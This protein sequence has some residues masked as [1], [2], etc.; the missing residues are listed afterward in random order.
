MSPDP[1]TVRRP[2]G[3]VDVARL[4]Q[5]S[6]ST[7]SRALRGAGRVSPDRRER[8]LRAAAELSYVPL[9]AAVRL[10]SGRGNTVGVVLPVASRW[11]FCEVVIGAARTLRAAGYDLHLY[12]VPPADPA[13]APDVSALRGRVDALLLIA[14]A[15]T[16]DGLGRWPE[17]GVPVVTVG[18]HP[19]TPARVGVDDRTGAATA[20][21]HLLELGHRD[22][23]MIAGTVD[24]PFA[25]TASRERQAG[26]TEALAAAGIGNPAERL[27]RRPWGVD[28]GAAAMAELLDGGARPTAVFAESDEMAFGALQVLRR[29]G[30]RVPDDVSVAGFDDHEMAAAMDL[31]TI[32]QPVAEQGRA[33]A[34]MLLDLLGGGPP[35][36]EVLLPTR[37]VVRGSTA[38]PPG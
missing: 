16:D 19:Q 23:H 3:I 2:V 33:A 18:G 1:V 24:A 20:A 21:R 15:G 27:V 32:A 13:G 35:G 37:L 17:L 31:T 26:F 10:S 30:L 34:S 22:V 36:G 4:A 12:D 11:F 29:R 9:Q 25:R 6:P 28:G 8:V 5:V 14:S 7:V 38:P